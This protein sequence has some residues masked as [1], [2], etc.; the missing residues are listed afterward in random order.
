MISTILIFT[1]VLSLLVFVHEFGHFITAKKSGVRVDEFGFG[2][3][4]RVAGIKKGDTIYSI[5][6]IP[7]GGFVKIKGE[8][9]E[10]S[11]DKDSFANKGAMTRGLI[12]TAGVLMNV[13]LAWFL[14]SAGYVFGMPQVVEDVS[15]YARVI[16]PK[17]QIVQV[18]KGS[19]AE[20]AGIETGDAIVAV[21]GMAITSPEDIKA[22]T[23]TREGQAVSVTV[24]R[25]SETLEKQVVPA[26]IKETGHPGLGVALVKTGLVTYP[27]WLAPA[28]GAVATWSFTREIVGAFFGL[29]RD[30]FVRQKVTVE[31]SGP[32]GI[33]VITSEVA[34]LGFRY[35]MQFTALL[36]LNLAIINIL[37]FPALDGGRVLFLV[38]EKIRGRAVGRRLETVAHNIGFALLM[39]L[40]LFVTLHDVSKFGGRLWEGLSRFFVGG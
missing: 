39:L 26:V 1:A 17:V 12:L 36:S 8:S 15:P 33:A 37:P 7:L 32:V 9:G 35:L 4:P 3:P 25:K 6:W 13:L 2:F 40:V 38:V 20:Q 29:I 31:F 28:Q 24:R 5:N 30:L 22:Y 16:D 23:G 27:L 21:G 18:L 14:L 34:K 11:R 10:Y 19:P